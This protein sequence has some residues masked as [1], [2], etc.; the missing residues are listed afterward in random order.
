[1][2]LR[3][4][5]RHW[6]TPPCVSG[7]AAIAD[8]SRAGRAPGRARPSVQHVELDAPAPPQP[9]CRTWATR[10]LGRSTAGEQRKPADASPLDDSTSRDGCGG[11]YTTSAEDGDSSPCAAGALA[12]QLRV[13]CASWVSRPLRRQPATYVSSGAVSVSLTL[14]LLTSGAYSWKSSIRLATGRVLH[15]PWNRLLPLSSQWPPQSAR[16][17]GARVQDATQSRSRRRQR[18]RRLPLAARIG[19]ECS[20]TRHMETT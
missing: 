1:M 15:W 5:S 19:P 4:C 18:M 8:A 12:C 6:P 3:N 10:P 11:E 13:S 9:R 14:L 16:R 17:L 7:L 20:T 2:W